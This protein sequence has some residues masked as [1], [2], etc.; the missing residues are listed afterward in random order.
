MFTLIKNV[1]VYQPEDRGIQDI[2]LC[3]EKIVE[4]G[5][6]LAGLYPQ[7]HSIEGNGMLAIPGYLDQH[8]HVTGGGG[9]GGFRTRV[10]ELRL[11]DCIQAGVTT[12]VGL[13]GTDGITR[14]VENLVAKTKALNEEGIT[15]FCLSGSYGYPSVTLTGDLKKDIAFIQEV[16]GVK[17]AI[18]DHRSSHVQ[19]NELIRVASYVRQAALI[20]GKAGLVVC[21]VGA[22]QGQLTMIF[23]VL[24]ETD[25][26]IKHFRPTHVQRVQEQA[27]EFAK[28]GGYIDFTASDNPQGPATSIVAALEAGAPLE[29]I[30]LSSDA[31]GSMPRWNERNEMIG[32]TAAS[33]GSIHKVILALIQE[34]GLSITEAISL[35]TTNVAQALELEKT[36]G[37]VSPGFDADILLLDQALRIDSVFAR[38]RKMMQGGRLLVKGTF[39]R[40]PS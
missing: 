27:V 31:N 39:E 9:E 19:K 37:R 6:N 26:P 12:V 7:A 24:A 11:S 34:K 1:H 14:S 33:M 40:D 8:V 23:E 5:A 3:H 32:I 22:G 13:L 10:P 28:L 18:S 2:L 20:S 35:V 38:G 17:L 29:R 21:H 30:T 4:I 36:K 16:L 15:A 25:L